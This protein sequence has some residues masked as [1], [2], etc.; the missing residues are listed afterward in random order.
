MCNFSSLPNSHPTTAMNPSASSKTSGS[1]NVSR[2]QLCPGSSHL[3]SGGSLRWH[4]SSIPPSTQLGETKNLQ[5]LESDNELY[6]ILEDDTPSILKDASISTKVVQASSPKQK[7]VSPPK[8]RSH[9]KS[10]RKF[11]LKAVPSFP[12]LTPCIDAKKCSHQISS[13]PQDSGITK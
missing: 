3:V 8:I 2:G 6:E 13:D 7:R 5:G 11:I 9:L 4:S 12:P 1:I 10:G